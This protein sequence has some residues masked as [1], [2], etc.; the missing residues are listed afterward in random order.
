MVK[1]EVR[2]YTMETRG[3]EY[4]VARLNKTDDRITILEQKVRKNDESI[5]RVI[6]IMTKELRL[7]P[8]VKDLR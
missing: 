3:A 8:A 4:T 7:S 2:V 1:L 6:D 5:D